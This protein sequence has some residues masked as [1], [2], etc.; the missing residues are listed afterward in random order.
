MHVTLPGGIQIDYLID[1]QNRRIGKEVNGTL[2]Q[3]FLYQDGLKP[4]AE[5]D[6]SNHIV[7]IFVYGSRSNVPDYMVRGG[8][9]YRI[10]SDHLGSPRLVM[11]SGTG[12]IL[13]RIDYDEFGNILQDTNPGFQPFGFAGGLYDRDTKLT[14]FGTRDYNSETGRW[15]AK[16]PIGFGGREANLYSYVINDPINS[17]DPFGL[18]SGLD[19][20]SP[21]DTFQGTDQERYPGILDLR[22]VTAARNVALLLL[23]FPPSPLSSILVANALG[24]FVELRQIACDPHSAFDPQDFLSNFVGS[25]T[26][27]IPLQ[28]R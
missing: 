1:G 13:Q 11:N 2:V 9:T 12:A 16:D 14:R 28:R 24:L 22:H 17:Q 10:I 5:L 18:Q 19:F 23:P 20:E 7:S 3:V 21:I 15:T 26:S 25:A 27:L 4:I 8:V 6:G